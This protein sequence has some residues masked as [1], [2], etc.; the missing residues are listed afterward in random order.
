[1]KK[2][3][4]LFLAFQMLSACAFY[5]DPSDAAREERLSAKQATQGCSMRDDNQGIRDC[6]LQTA[7]KNSPKTYTT[8]ELS[9]GQPIAVVKNTPVKAQPV[10]EPLNSLDMNYGK[11]AEGQSGATGPDN[12]VTITTTIEATG[13]VVVAPPTV[14]MTETVGTQPVNVSS[15]TGKE[16]YPIVV[17]EKEKPVVKLT[18]PE[19]KSAAQQKNSIPATVEPLKENDP[20][21]W[22]KYVSEKKPEAVKK[23]GCPC[24]D[25]NDPCPQ[26]YEK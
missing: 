9:S 21:W 16:S 23:E 18:A 26:C 13:P 14:A 22:D 5:E 6:V 3:F 25:P 20:K 19:T 15:G 11:R 4:C 24:K 7:D 17:G 2:L 8:G 10:Y 1:M 12:Q